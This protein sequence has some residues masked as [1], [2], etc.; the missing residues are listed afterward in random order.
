MLNEKLTRL[1]SLEETMQATEESYYAKNNQKLLEVSEVWDKAKYSE[2]NAVYQKSRLSKIINICY[3]NKKLNDLWVQV[4]FNNIN[5]VK[6]LNYLM[7]SMNKLYKDERNQ[8]DEN[9]RKTEIFTKISRKFIEAIESKRDFK[10]EMFGQILSQK[11]SKEQFSMKIDE[12]S[13]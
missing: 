6:K 1:K 8:I 7:N 4:L 5:K 9:K 12:G 10:K 2:N 13:I 3:K 11:N